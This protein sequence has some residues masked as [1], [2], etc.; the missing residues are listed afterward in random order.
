V[1]RRMEEFDRNYKQ[2][3]PVYEALL[4]QLNQL[5]L[6]GENANN[7]LDIQRAY[8]IQRELRF[9]EIQL[10]KPVLALDHIDLRRIIDLR[11]FLVSQFT[12]LTTQQ[13]LAWLET[14]SSFILTHEIHEIYTR[15]QGLLHDHQVLG[16]QFN[17]LIAGPSGSGKTSLLFL[18]ASY[19]PPILSG[20]RTVRAVN[21]TDAPPFEKSK[22]A[23]P[24]RLLQDAGGFFARNDSEDILYDRTTI[25][26]KQSNT[27]LQIID[28]AQNLGTDHLRRRFIDFSNRCQ[29]SIVCASSDPKKF[30]EHDMQTRG[31]WGKSYDLEPY[32]ENRLKGLLGH[33]DL[34]L[35]FPESSGLSLIEI[36]Q[37]KGK[38]TV[39]GPAQFIQDKTG[40]I[41]R[42]ILRLVVRSSQTALKSN[43]A[44]LSIEDL[45]C[46]A[47][48]LNL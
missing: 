7:W 32:K 48:E 42:D 25:Y 12:E 21:F 20:N 28:E 33:I 19:N 8:K 13:K 34:L 24:R 46:A 43:R 17:L 27:V 29:V 38:E 22:K 4:D 31:R 37:K 15:I 16:Q 36:S 47:D 18:L 10:I 6:S 9:L 30:L 40:G 41:L 5:D 14:F 45:K 35:P 44:R 23:L 2:L 11:R 3:R 26:Y 1:R 39:P